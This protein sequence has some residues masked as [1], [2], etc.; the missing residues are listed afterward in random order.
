MSKADML[1]F[2]L[3]RTKQSVIDK[4]FCFT[5]EEW[6]KSQYE[7]LKKLKEKDLRDI[8]IIRSSAVK[9]DH[10]GDTQAG[11][12]KSILN[13][14][15]NNEDRIKAAIFEVIDSYYQKNNGNPL[16]QVIVQNQLVGAKL[17]HCNE[18]T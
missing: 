17:R 18:I 10:E 7:I 12:Y 13:V 5:I 15:A 4:F 9:E 14:P 11:I 2:L 1:E 3:A 16:N 8:L 6:S